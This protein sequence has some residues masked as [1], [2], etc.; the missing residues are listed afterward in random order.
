MELTD[1]TF[2]TRIRRRHIPLLSHQRRLRH[3]N[4]VLARN[5][6]SAEISEDDNFGLLYT[7][8]LHK[9]DGAIYTSETSEGNLNPIWQQLQL[10]KFNSLKSNSSASFII[11]VW[12]VKKGVTTCLIE[13]DVNLRGLSFLGEQV[14]KDGR[15]FLPNTLLFSMPEGIYG[16]GDCVVKG[17]KTDHPGHN[18]FE[19]LY[20]DPSIVRNSCTVNTLRRMMTTER[21]IKQTQVSVS[22]VRRAIEKKLQQRVRLHR[23]RARE[24]N[25]RLRISLL[26]QEIVQRQSKL[27]QEKLVCQ[28]RNKE[29]ADRGKELENIAS[30]LVAKRNSLVEQ[31]RQYFQ[32]R[33]NLLKASS[34][35]ALRQKEL[36]SE[37]A[38][39]Y[40]I[41]QFPDKKGYSICFV[42][43]PNSEDF[44]DNS[45]VLPLYLL[46][47]LLQVPLLF[48][49]K[50]DALE[51]LRCNCNLATKDL[52][53]TLHN[54]HGLFEHYSIKASGSGQV[55]SS[56][57]LPA[58]SHSVPVPIQNNNH[59]DVTDNLPSSDEV[60]SPPVQPPPIEGSFPS[61]TSH[62]TDGELATSPKLS[63]SLDEG[64]DQL[65]VSSAE[66]KLR[67]SLAPNF[68]SLQASQHSSE[69]NL[70]E[71]EARNAL[72]VRQG[73]ASIEE[74]LLPVPPVVYDATEESASLHSGDGVEVEVAVD[75]LFDADLTAR[76]EVLA[77][78][79]RSF[80]TYAPPFSSNVPS[81]KQ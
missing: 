46:S 26:E 10:S 21:A 56:A 29:Q 75:T 66:T 27:E 19:V 59:H 54:L 71:F 45:V 76:T 53:F 42:H 1:Y 25:L 39:V 43:L 44:N 64:L 20:S 41:A 11:R 77:N 70:R 6:T 58:P 74:C 35:L 33:E 55:S 4:A 62:E 9:D 34:M 60:L 16:P 2:D 63:S 73:G 80:Q 38:F 69:P 50:S 72:R 40:P 37:L 17:P 48:K 3:L 5:I 57:L 65:Q 78:I 81:T 31:R 61:C 32:V 8:H 18:A 30:E 13:W 36:I 7:I 15:K 23:S 52:R 51:Q 47:V 28:A 68:Q 49:L 79:V 67:Q 12:M 14:P 22:R 24:E